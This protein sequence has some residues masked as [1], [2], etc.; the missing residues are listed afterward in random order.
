MRTLN[1]KHPK[2]GHAAKVPEYRLKVRKCKD[3]AARDH[4]SLLGTVSSLPEV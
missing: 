3:Q 2:T 1:E 4:V